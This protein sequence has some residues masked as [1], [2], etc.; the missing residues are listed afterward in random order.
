MRVIALSRKQK[1]RLARTIRTVVVVV[2]FAMT[3][4]LAIRFAPYLKRLL[5][6]PEAILRLRDAI[7]SSG[8]LGAVILTGIQFIQVVTALLPSEPIELAAGMSY[9]GMLGFL[10]CECGV[11]LGSFVVIKLVRRFGQP[12]VSA[13]FN[14]K[15]Q[16]QFAFLQK[17][18][19]LEWITFVLYFIPGLP[20]DVFTYLA[21]LTPIKPSRFLLISSLSRIPSIAVSTFGGARLIVGDFRSA[22]FLFGCCGLAGFIGMLFYRLLVRRKNASNHQKL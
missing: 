13:F 4:L 17:S 2:L 5:T 7:Q 21:G 12:L 20:K 15:H 1:A 18:D 22:V 10:I 9:G 19:R 11:L 14:E 8:L 3:A 6:D 16:K